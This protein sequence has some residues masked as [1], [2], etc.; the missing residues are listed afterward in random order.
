MEKL[1]HYTWRHKIF[2]LTELR[3][4]DGRLVEVVDVGLYNSSDGGPDFFNAKIKIDG[5]LWIGNVELHMKASDWYRHHHD[6]DAAYDNVVLHVVEQADMDVT[7][8]QGRLL[9]ALEIPVPSVMKKDYAE[10]INSERYPP[11]YKAIPQI[12]R[13]KIYSWMSALQSERLEEKT[14]AMVSRVKEMDGSWEAGYFATMARSFGFGINGDA[15][16]TWVRHI[17]MRAVDHHRDDLFQVET[18]F[19]GQANLLNKVDDKYRKEYCYL[20]KKFGLS[21]MN[22][23]LWRY[24]RTRPQNFPHARILQLA[25]MYHERRTGLSDLLECKDVKAIG[26]LY[27]MK[28]STLELLIINAAIPTIFAYGRHH[29]K[30]QYCEK[31]FDLLEELKAEDNSIVR[32]WRECGLEAHNAGDSQALIQLKKEYCDRKEC[33]RCRFGFEFLSGE[34]RNRFLSDAAPLDPPS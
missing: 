24:L 17:P 32:M 11:C 27:G 15:F 33:L 26:R 5:M 4:T 14:M 30:E 20:Q 12:P 22:P 3:T 28:G 31:A 34:Y 18:L 21:A 9:P 23:L 25:R 2:P 13:L 8:S 29:A 7:T 16:E 1:L 19:I 6:G 10:L